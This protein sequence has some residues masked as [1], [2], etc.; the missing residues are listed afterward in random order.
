[1]RIGQTQ[2]KPGKGYHFPDGPYVEYSGDIPAD[3]REEVKKLAE[4]EL[5]RLIQEGMKPKG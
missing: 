3:K 4:E 1:M 2:L 5:N